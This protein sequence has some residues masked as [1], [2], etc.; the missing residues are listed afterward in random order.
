MLPESALTLPDLM[1]NKPLRTKRLTQLNGEVF[2][3]EL[4]IKLKRISDQLVQVKGDKADDLVF[5]VE[6][7]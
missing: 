6:K 3:L 2:N 1:I 4:N 7:E 5:Y